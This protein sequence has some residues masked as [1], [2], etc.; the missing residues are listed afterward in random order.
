MENEKQ[1]TRIQFTMDE[2]EALKYH[3]DSERDSLLE[4]IT[5]HQGR[6]EMDEAHAWKATLNQLEQIYNKINK[7]LN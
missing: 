5:D 2:L 4:V 3:L 1:N 6:N 7:H